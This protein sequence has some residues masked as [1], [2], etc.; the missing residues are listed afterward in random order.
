MY[1]II[2]T[3]W[4]TAKVRDGYYK[5]GNRNLHRLIY[6]DY[7]RCKLSPKTHVHHINGNKL[8]NSI[9][10]LIALTPAEH[11]DEHKILK[12]RLKYSNRTQKHEIVQ[13]GFPRIIVRRNGKYSYL[14]KYYVGDAISC[15]R[16]G[17][18]IDKDI[19]KLKHRVK[20]RGL[21]WVEEI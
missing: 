7:H 20:L 9:E 6:E 15:E 18:I 3:K 19:E 17:Q 4:G 1:P 11:R 16:Y 14:W 13:E 10:N 12:K 8:D 5:V 21:T 2:Y